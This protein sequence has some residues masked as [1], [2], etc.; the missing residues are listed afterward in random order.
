MKSFYRRTIVGGLVTG[1]MAARFSLAKENEMK[2]ECSFNDQVFTV[3]LV[4]NPS[5]RDLLSLLPLNDLSITDYATN[6]KIAYLPRKLTEAGAARFGN[7]A[8]GDLCY[9]APWGNLAFFH[10]GYR[11]SGGLIRLGRLDGGTGPLLVRGSFPLRI[12]SLS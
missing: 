8:P 6:E 4:D 3:T 12:R 7:E 2:I 9:Y 5:A 11:W 10:A 1:L